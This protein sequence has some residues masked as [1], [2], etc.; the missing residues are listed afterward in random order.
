CGSEV[1]SKLGFSSRDSSK[2]SLCQSQ[3]LHTK[4]NCSDKL[5]ERRVPCPELGVAECEGWLLRRKAQK[6]PVVRLQQPQQQ[7]QPA[8][9]RR[10]ALLR[11]TG[12]FLYRTPQVSYLPG[13]S[14]TR[15][16][17][18]NITRK[19]RSALESLDVP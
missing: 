14:V 1:P 19:T 2:K 4:S 7:P 8:W 13:I 5:G 9:H 6:G 10:W 17:G 11:G 15:L 3:A 16:T 12:L 18:Y